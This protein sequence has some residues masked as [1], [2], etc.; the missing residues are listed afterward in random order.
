[1]RRFARYWDLIANSGNFIETTPLL[2]TAPS[3]AGSAR[4]SA[5][6]R[7]PSNPSCV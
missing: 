7:S 2:W 5:P 3:A 4:E 6:D 1:M